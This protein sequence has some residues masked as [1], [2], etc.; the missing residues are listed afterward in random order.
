[1]KKDFGRFF[2]LLLLLFSYTYC[3]CDKGHTHTMTH[4]DGSL[5][6][7]C[8]RQEY[9]YYIRGRRRRGLRQRVHR[10]FRVHKIDECARAR[11]L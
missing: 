6:A 4:D 7:L 2:F 1:M 3:V 10:I 5:Y 9:T 8:S 11:V